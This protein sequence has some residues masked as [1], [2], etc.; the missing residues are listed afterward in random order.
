MIQGA[1]SVYRT[2]NILKMIIQQE[3]TPS[4]LK[5]VSEAME[6]TTQIATTTSSSYRDFSVPQGQLHYYWGQPVNAAGAGP[7]SAVDSGY[8]GDLVPPQTA[9]TFVTAGDG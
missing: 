9:P 1:Q 7:V 5:E 8:S 2:L 4:T 6:I 3:E